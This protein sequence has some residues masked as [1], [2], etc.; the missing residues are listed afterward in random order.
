MRGTQNIVANTLSRTFDSSSPDALNRVACHLAV[1]AFLLEFSEHEQLRR[2]YSALADFIA[3]LEGGDK[4]RNYSLSYGTLYCRSS[5]IR[6]QR[7][8][9]PSTA[10]PTDFAN[11]QDSPLVGEVDVFN[12]L[13][14]IRSQ[15]VRKECTKIFF[16]ECEPAI[17]VP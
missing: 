1:T 15:F 13:N 17:R 12:T 11:F 5:K 16:R 14:N 10:I 2:Q 9:I 6:C 3:K 7:L 4:V 8:V